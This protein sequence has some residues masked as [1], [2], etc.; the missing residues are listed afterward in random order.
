MTEP[1]TDHPL[2]ALRPEPRKERRGARIIQRLAGESPHADTAQLPRA[3]FGTPG[4]VTAAGLVGLLVLGV[5]YTLYF[6]RT[7][8]V[9][10]TAAILLGFLLKPLI[11]LLHNFGIPEMVGTVVV[12]L[13]FIVTVG[14]S[15]YLLAPPAS[16]M[17]SRLPEDAAQAEVRLRGIT[18]RFGE[19]REAVDE[20]A[21]VSTGA[22]EAA[23]PEVVRLAP[24]LLSARIIGGARS[25]VVGSLAAAFLLFLLLA[26]GQTFLR[27]T[28]SM[29]PTLDQQ[30]RLLRII[31][32]IERDLSVYMVTTSIINTVLG[33]AVGVAL[34]LIGVPN[35]VLW[36]VAVAVLNFAPYIGGIVGSLMIGL[37]AVAS[38]DDLGRALLAPLSYLVLNA[39][40]SYVITPQIIG[41]RF[42]I[43]PVAVFVAVA[44]WGWIWGIPGAF[45]AVPILTAASIV[46]ANIEPLRPIAQLL[47]A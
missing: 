5:L 7:L 28:I 3:D 2:Q 1:P 14:M 47:R 6:A 27:R 16:R 36:G 20:V 4:G 44:F 43:N 8:L 32:G 15:V 30:K 10:I 45:L 18:Q 35:P 25:L 26:S 38:I 9:P 21:S 33:T 29:Q 22:A 13:T 39:L 12:F 11:R 17:L 24:E 42:S 37:V 46:C 40:E 41:A 19:M 31:Q 23:Q 34:F